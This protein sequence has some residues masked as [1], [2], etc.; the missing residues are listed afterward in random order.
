MISQTEQEVAAFDSNWRG[1]PEAAYSHWTRGKVKNQIQLAFRQ[2]WELFQEI[3]GRPVEKMKVLEVGCGRGT[4]SCYF[5][6]HGAT[7]S[8]LDSSN[9]VIERARGFFAGQNWQADFMVA[10]AQEIPQAEGTYDLVFSMGLLEHFEAPAKTIAEQLRVLRAGG[11]FLAYV[12]PHNPHCVQSQYEWINTLLK[13]YQGSGETKIEEKS[14]VYRSDFNS[15]Y[16]EK[17]L[18]EL[19]VD[20]SFVYGVYPLPMI[21]HSIDFPFSLMPEAAELDLV[22]HFEQV[23]A[24]RKVQF[25]QH[26][27]I[28]EEKVGQGFY[29][30]CQKNG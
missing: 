24:E 17:I 29:I 30:W 22:E 11:I 16:Y 14:A 4:M 20:F 5:A 18:K 9:A 1:R 12:I 7:V 8:L 3:L 10:D 23:L 25:Q 28:C 13:H 21:S 2:H 27:W 15:S 26:P 19:G 6:D